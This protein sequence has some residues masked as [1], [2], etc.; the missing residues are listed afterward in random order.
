MHQRAGKHQGIARTRLE[1]LVAIFGEDQ[2]ATSEIVA[3]A[4]RYG[5]AAMRFAGA[6]T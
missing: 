3:E 4:D 2:L 6:F 1:S 5:E